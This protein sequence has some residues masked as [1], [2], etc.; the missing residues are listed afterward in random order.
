MTGACILAATIYYIQQQQYC[1][2]CT[3]VYIVLVLR[4]FDMETA[5]MELTPAA[6]R[7]YSS[8]SS[9]NLLPAERVSEAVKGTRVSECD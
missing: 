2:Q 3:A 1:T 5:E 8:S 6:Y 9:R 7:S 4:R